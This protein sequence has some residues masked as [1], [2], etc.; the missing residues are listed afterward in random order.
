[1]SSW[2]SYPSIFNLGHKAIERLLD[3]PVNVEEKI[4]GSQFSFGLIDGQ[5]RVKSKSVEMNVEAPREDVR[6][7]GFDG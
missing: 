3:G 6:K 5:I 2:H 7:S 4:D 1:M